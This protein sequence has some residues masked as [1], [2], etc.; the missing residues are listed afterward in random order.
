[1][2]MAYMMPN[3][4][5]YHPDRI[6]AYLNNE[7][8]KPITVKV[9]LTDKCNLRCNYCVY[10][11]RIS[12]DE[13]QERNIIPIFDNLMWMG[14]KG[15]VFTGGE[16][17]C[18]PD[19]KEV[20]RYT[21]EVCNFDLGLITNGI[22]YPDI[23]EYLT[24]VRFSLDTVT[25]SLYTKIKGKDKL[26]TVLENIHRAVEEK[27]NRKL[28]ITVGVQM[29][30]TKENY[31]EIEAFLA[32]WNLSCMIDYCQIRPVEN[33]RYTDR[34]WNVINKQLKNIRDKTNFS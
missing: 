24:W 13:M 21:K 34:E 27:V 2:D 15:I 20:V 3:K 23:L 31:N 32:Y 18:Y 7:I 5:F 8:V 4:I 9:Y 10:K 28:P 17:T 30:V 26:T 14:V 33:Y 16:P 22:I 1:M 11:D 6:G 25:R 12:S 19:F 29:V